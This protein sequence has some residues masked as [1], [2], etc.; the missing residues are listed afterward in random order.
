M[1]EARDDAK[2]LLALLEDPE[3]SANFGSFYNDVGFSGRSLEAI[4]N[5]LKKWAQTKGIGRNDKTYEAIQRMA[6]MASEERKRFL[7]VAITA[8]E[9]QTVL[10]WLPDAGDSLS[11]MLNKAKFLGFEADQE[12]RRFLDLY[13]NEVDMSPWYKSFG[14]KRFDTDSKPG[15]KPGQPNPATGQPSTATGGGRLEQK[16]PGLVTE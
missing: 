14:I 4:E 2:E 6:R 15:R 5:K 9:L 3:V 11:V 10:G 1:G 12:F 8:P 7:G 13:K 16:Y